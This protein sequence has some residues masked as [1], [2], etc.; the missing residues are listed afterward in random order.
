[1][2]ISSRLHFSKPVFGNIYSTAV[3]GVL[4]Y[5]AFRS[6]CLLRNS[7]NASYGSLYDR[8]VHLYAVYLLEIKEIRDCPAAWKSVPRLPL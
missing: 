2:L 8:A 3:R 4:L 5:L 6:G 1:M 7:D